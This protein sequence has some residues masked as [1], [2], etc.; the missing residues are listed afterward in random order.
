MTRPIRILELRS[1]RGTGG[2]PEKTILLGAARADP[3]RFAI[4]VCY[5]RDARDPIFSIDAKAGHLP[6]DYLEIVERHSF[7]A[8]IWSRLRALVREKSIDIVHSHEYK[9]DL[10]A[11]LLAKF[12]NVTALS[13]VHG[14]TGHSRREHW[15]YYPIDKRVLS[16]FPQLIAVSNDIRHELIRHGARPER[17]VTILNGIDHHRFRR[18]QTLGRSIR[19]EVGIRDNDVV[20]GSVGRLE[21]QK[22]FDL[23]IQAFAEARRRRP[24]LKLL[25]AGDGSLRHVLADLAASLGLAD[26]C[27]LLGERTDI[28]AL[29]GAFDMF[30]QSS[31]YEGTPNAVLEAMALETPVIATDVGGTAELVRSHVDGLIVPPDS[32]PAW[33]EAIDAVLSNPDATSFRV[34]AARRRVETDLS[35][36]TRMAAVEAIYADLFQRRWQDGVAPAVPAQT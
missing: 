3:R 26:S 17:V 10:L 7:D 36:D 12:E 31:D 33:I 2:G 4:T 21:P 14:W 28:I 11:W 13:T 9:T 8:S 16:L 23:L 34:A 35:F 32:V 20:I 15:L 5:L 22:R 25:I 18:D 29:H 1:V 6:V 27:R 24:E 19:T 30:V